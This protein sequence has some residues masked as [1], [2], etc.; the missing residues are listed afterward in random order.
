MAPKTN[1]TY[2]LAK[3]GY[4][5]FSNFTPSVNCK[6][7]FDQSTVETLFIVQKISYYGLNN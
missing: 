7:T 1:V 5:L 3:F 4:E 2:I 6:G